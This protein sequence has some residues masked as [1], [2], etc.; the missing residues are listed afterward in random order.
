MP[1]YSVSVPFVPTPKPVVRAML[2]IANAGPNDIVYDLGCGD[3]RILVIAL[4][5]FD[6]KKAVGVEIREDKVREAIENLKKAGVLN[7]AKVIHGDMFE[8]DISEATI[9]TLFL[10]TSVNEKLKPK[11]ERELKRGT[12]VVS[13]EF[14]IPG[15]TPKKVVDVRDSNFISHTIYL[16]IVGEHK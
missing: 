5:E 11:L 3:G 8:V 14:R 16:Y 6:V 12:R 13:H 4:R 9:V 2:K 1:S 15:W 7:R 10:L